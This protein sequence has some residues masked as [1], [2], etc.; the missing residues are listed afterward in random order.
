M[1]PFHSVLLLLT[2]LLAAAPLSAAGFKEG[3]HYERL[4]AA[5][6]VDTPDK[7]EVRELFW[8]ACPH[9]YK[10]EPLLHDWLEKKPDDVVFVR[11]PAVFGPSW[12]LLARAYYTAEALGVVDRVHQPLFDYLHKLR[13]RL[14]TPTDV[15]ALFVKQGIDGDAFDKAWHSFPVV[16][17]TNRSRR[18]QELYGVTGVPTLIVNGKYR[19]TATLAGGNQKM[20]QVI[21]YLV[22]LERKQLAAGAKGA[23]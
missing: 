8:Y 12:E 16:T 2:M 11:M 22:G 18:V 23:R 20:L 1:K 10:F 5:Q 9:C 19:T 21:D 3:V 7:V 15:K 4:A 14:R 13:K 6:P 17:K